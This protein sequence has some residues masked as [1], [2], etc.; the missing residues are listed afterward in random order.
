MVCDIALD[1]VDNG[2]SPV[3]D[4]NSQLERLQVGRELVSDKLER[5]F[6]REA[7]DS[8]AEYLLMT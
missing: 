1:G 4:S 5:H 3:G 6:A 2:L 7:V 8:Q